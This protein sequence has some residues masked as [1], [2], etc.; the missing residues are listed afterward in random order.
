MGKRDVAVR[1][2]RA[3]LRTIAG[4]P[5][6]FHVLAHAHFGDELAEQQHSLTT[7]S[8]DLDRLGAGVL[9]AA[10]LLLLGQ[11]DAGDAEQFGDLLLRHIHRREL[12]LA[13][14][15]DAERKLFG[16]HVMHPLARH[17]RLHLQDGRTGR[18]D[19]HHGET[20]ALL[21]Q[22]QR[23][24]HRL[25]S[26]HDVLGIAERDALDVHR[27]LER[28]Q[29][30]AHLDGE[31][32]VVGPPTP[33]SGRALLPN[34]RGWRHL[35]AGH[36]VDGVVDEE[37]RYVFAAIGGVHNLCGANG[38]QV[39]VTLVADDRGLGIAPFEGRGNGRCAPV[40]RLHVAR[41]EVVVGKHRAAHRADH[42]GVFLHAQVAERF[43]DQLVGHAVAAAGTIVRLV[44]IFAVKGL[45]E[46][47]RFRLGN[48]V[49]AHRRLLTPAL[50]CG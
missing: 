50:P 27:R 11:P 34:E 42:D 38:R 18:E 48:F 39:S 24:M 20:G 37:D 45:E 41:V 9:A 5:A 23:L 22:L 30:L 16:Q 36:A 21:L 14:A 28:R 25:A 12:R 46:D 3:H 35:S 13:V 31:A 29:H 17:H 10:V 15:K 49:F 43:G 26:L 8:C 33:G 32:F 6:H 40:R 44:L 1:A 47:R 4:Q 19:L 2:A 7:K